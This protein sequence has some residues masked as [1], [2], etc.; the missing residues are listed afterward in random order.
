MA[1]VHEMDSDGHND[2][3]RFSPS[4]PKKQKETEDTPGQCEY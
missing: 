2:Y 3:Y 4:G 1:L